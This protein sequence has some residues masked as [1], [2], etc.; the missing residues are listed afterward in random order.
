MRIQVG[1]AATAD[2]REDRRAVGQRRLQLLV[3][4]RGADR[5]DVVVG[6]VV[7][8]DIAAAVADLV[9]DQVAGVDQHRHGGEHTLRRL[10]RDRAADRVV[11]EEPQIVAGAR[12]V[13]DPVIAGLGAIGHIAARGRGDA[14]VAT[15]QRIE[16]P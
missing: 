11:V 13:E 15:R 8:I 9:E 1:F 5:E 4:V 10:A 3:G 6:R 12:R 16:G 7:A 14:R 2:A